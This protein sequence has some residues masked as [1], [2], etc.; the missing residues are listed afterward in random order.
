MVASISVGWPGAVGVA[1]FEVRDGACRSWMGSETLL[2]W[3]H[4]V[5]VVPVGLPVG[6][7]PWN[8]GR[9]CLEWRHTSLHGWHSSLDGWPKPALTLAWRLGDAGLEMEAADGGP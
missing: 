3:A 7:R 1:A 5:A 8:W 6:V 4:G 9:S 2:A